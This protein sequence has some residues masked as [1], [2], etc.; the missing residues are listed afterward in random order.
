M[1]KDLQALVECESPTDDLDACYRVVNLSKE[2]TGNLIGTP[3]DI[4]DEKGRP[5][6]GLALANHK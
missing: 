6:I 5:V 2:I 3:A 4:L 1:L